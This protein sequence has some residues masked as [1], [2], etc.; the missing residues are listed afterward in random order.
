M[1]VDTMRAA[2]TA[3]DRPDYD[4]LMALFEPD[5]AL[6]ATLA[7]LDPETARDIRL[8][9]AK[10]KADRIIVSMEAEVREAKDGDRDAYRATAERMVRI[11]AAYREW[12]EEQGLRQGPV[13]TTS[14]EE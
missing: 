11:R 1:A 7:G 14:T 6:N 9:V 13:S 3:E 2:L 4:D 12:Q 5:D 8:R 10:A